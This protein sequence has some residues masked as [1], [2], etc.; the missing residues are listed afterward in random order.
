MVWVPERGRGSGPVE[1]D[2]EVEIVVIGVVKEVMEVVETSEPPSL[3]TS[4]SACTTLLT[5]AISSSRKIDVGPGEFPSDS[6]GKEAERDLVME[7]SSML[8]DCENKLESVVVGAA[9]N[10]PL[11]PVLIGVEETTEIVGRSSEAI[12]LVL[13]YSE[14]TE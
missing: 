12:L 11:A 1:K 6:V 10:K 8:E 3:A 7:I 14:I 4:S 2:I 5:D 13:I 9:I